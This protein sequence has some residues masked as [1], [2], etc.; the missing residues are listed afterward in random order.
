MWGR[1]MND[2]DDR[3]EKLEKQDLANRW[4][5]HREDCLKLAA[6]LGATSAEQAIEIAEKLGAYILSGKQDEPKT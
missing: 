1:A 5:R 3:L 4:Q 6:K 2:L